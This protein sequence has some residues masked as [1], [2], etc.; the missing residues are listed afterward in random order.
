MKR[1]IACILVAFAAFS[2]AWADETV[3]LE[4]ESTSNGTRPVWVPYVDLSL[5]LASREVVYGEVD[6]PKKTLMG[7][8]TLS[9]YFAENFGIFGDLWI[10]N[11]WNNW[12]KDSKVENEPD[13]FDYNFGVFYALE[14]M[15]LVKQLKFTLYHDRIHYPSRSGWKMPGETK[16]LL[17]LTIETA[18]FDI[19]QNLT[20]HPGTQISFDYENDEWNVSPFAEL[21]WEICDKLSL[22]NRAELFWGNARWNAGTANRYVYGYDEESDTIYRFEHPRYKNAI[23]SFMLGTELAYKVTEN[24]S[25]A[26]YGKL[27]WAVDHD[28]RDVWKLSDDQHNSSGCDDVVGVRMDF[29]F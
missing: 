9:W 5:D 12:E 27:M 21:K 4:G 24:I 8:L 6:N 14:D 23:T 20:W 15:P 28:I 11:P 1:V 19:C 29:S 7:D 17:N 2:M 3:K 16:N 18:D 26:V 25:V 10:A 22:T 13:E